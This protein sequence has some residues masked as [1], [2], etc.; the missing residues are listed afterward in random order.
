MAPSSENSK[1]WRPAAMFSLFISCAAFRPSASNR[2]LTRF[3]GTGITMISL[4]SK[5]CST[6]AA[7]APKA[8]QVEA[9]FLCGMII[10]RTPSSRANTPACAGPAPP[11]ANSTKSRGS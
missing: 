8:H 9:A 2:S 5:M 10:F 11:K 3:A 7:A 4:C 1:R 6:S